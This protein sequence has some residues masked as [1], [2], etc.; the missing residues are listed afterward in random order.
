MGI[1]KVPEVDLTKC[2]CLPHDFKVTVLNALHYAAKA[3]ETK[4]DFYF[5]HAHGLVGKEP[6][7]VEQREQM[8]SMGKQMEHD[9]KYFHDLWL[10]FDKIPQCKKE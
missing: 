4:S 3:A 7:I 1:S 2:K 6:D 5:A 9:A 10:T 8:E